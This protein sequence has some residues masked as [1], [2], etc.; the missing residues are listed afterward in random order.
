MLFI[1]YYCHLGEKAS[2]IT[3]SCF[4]NGWKKGKASSIFFALAVDCPKNT[5]SLKSHVPRPILDVIMFGRINEQNV[6]RN[7]HFI[8]ILWFHYFRPNNG[9]IPFVHGVHDF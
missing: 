7:D 4:W 2:P 9:I 8:R 3:H 1:N 5:Q 6:V